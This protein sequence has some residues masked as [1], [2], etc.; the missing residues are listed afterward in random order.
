MGNAWQKILYIWVTYMN[1]KV[2]PYTIDD[3]I[4]MTQLGG[5]NNMLVNATIF[6]H[7]L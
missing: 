4:H 7:L 1:Y 2:S 3:S 6:F 5:Y